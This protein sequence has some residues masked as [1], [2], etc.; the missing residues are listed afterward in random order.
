MR[1]VHDDGV[2][3]KVCLI[4]SLYASSRLSTLSH[5][6]SKNKDFK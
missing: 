4:V 1:L 6:L 3:P 2:C 5:D